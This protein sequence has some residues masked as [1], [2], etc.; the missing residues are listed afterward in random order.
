M[1]GWI[2]VSG[3]ETKKYKIEWDGKQLKLIKVSK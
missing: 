2:L 1:T 3:K